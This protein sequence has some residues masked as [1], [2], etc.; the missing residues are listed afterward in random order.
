MP[1]DAIAKLDEVLR[2]DSAKGDA[3]A[4]G[5]GVQGSGPFIAKRL[6][7]ENSELDNLYGNPAIEL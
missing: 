1:R 7:I 4:E 2:E 5:L 6:G 3:D